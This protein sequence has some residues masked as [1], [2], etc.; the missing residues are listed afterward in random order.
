[1]NLSE[2][3]YQQSCDQQLR[4]K[5]REYIINKYFFVNVSTI[6]KS[7]LNRP[8]ECFSIGNKP[9]K[10]LLCGAFHG[11]EWITSSLLYIFIINICSSIINHKSLANEKIWEY[12]KDRSLCVIPCVNPDG[13]EISI[14]GSSSAKDLKGFIDIVSKGDT[15]HWQSNAMGVD[16][17][18]N[19]DA[20]WSNVKSKELA[21]GINF[22]S[23]TRYGGEEPESQP[24][25]IALTKFCR[26]NIIHSALA[27]HSQGEEI[28][29]DF[30]SNTPEQSQ[31]MA[32][33][34]SFLSG[35]KLSKPEGIAT[36]GGFKDWLIDELKI[37]A[38]TVEVGL[39]KNPLD[40]S[41]LK[42]IYI[43]TE[44]MLLYSLIM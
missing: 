11:M 25:T 27:F 4:H 7:V 6:G 28:Y 13:V 15:V 43:K 26:N 33:H 34:M 21:M 9:K 3:L 37:P 44:K 2:A 20:G 19:F 17:N 8:I 42:E 41:Q 10:V 16:I 30:G 40:I 39:G 38:F 32:E 29:W 24:E 35:Y 31:K 18:H 1:M 14:N 12:F 23:K 36:G 5:L 22:P